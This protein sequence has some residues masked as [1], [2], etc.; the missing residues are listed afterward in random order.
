MINQS[1]RKIGKRQKIDFSLFLSR[2]SDGLTLFCMILTFSTAKNPSQA[3]YVCDGP[4]FT[5]AVPSVADAASLNG[6]YVLLKRHP[7]RDSLKIVRVNSTM[8]CAPLHYNSMEAF[9]A[10][11]NTIILEA[12]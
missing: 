8:S 10:D 7:T 4:Q 12:S 3:P 5:I 1:Y 11:A 2:V 9:L 6:A